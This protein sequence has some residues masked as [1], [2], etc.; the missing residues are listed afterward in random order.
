MP[1]SKNSDWELAWSANLSRGSP[2]AFGIG[3]FELRN[4]MEKALQ[5][6][7]QFHTSKIRPQAAMDTKP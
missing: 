3:Q 5:S 6:D 2:Y 1:P 7:R 4:A